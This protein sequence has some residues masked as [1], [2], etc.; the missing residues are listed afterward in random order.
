[1]GTTQPI[2]NKKTLENFRNYYKKEENKPRNYALIVFGLNSALRISDIL[3]LKWKDVCN[4]T[5]YL[6]HIIVTEKK[7]GKKN[8]LALNRATKEA[9]DYYRKTIETIDSE[10]YIFSSQKVKDESITRSQ[11]FRIIQKAAQKCGM[12]E[13]VSCHS[14]R[15]TFGYY[16]WKNGTPPALLMSIYNHSSYEITKRYLGIEQLD[17]DE[18]YEK[19]V[20]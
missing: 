10:H 4:S 19:N 8:V 2:R 1:M 12:K 5:G 14:L 7:T 17:K 3:K 18:V 9:L 16:A 6:E 11:A 20:L 15:K 13:P